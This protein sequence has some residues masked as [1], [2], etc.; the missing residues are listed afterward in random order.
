MILWG[1][2]Q[3]K[4]RRWE[5]AREGLPER[6][7]DGIAPL[8]VNIGILWPNRYK[9]TISTTILGYETM[10]VRKSRKPV[11]KRLV[12]GVPVCKT[13][14]QAGTSKSMARQTLLKWEG[15]DLLRASSCFYCF[16]IPSSREL[17][18]LLI[19]P[20]AVVHSTRWSGP[21]NL[22]TDNYDVCPFYLIV[23]QVCPSKCF[24]YTWKRRSWKEECCHLRSPPPSRCWDWKRESLLLCLCPKILLFWWFGAVEVIMTNSLG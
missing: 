11:A 21:L 20:P 13:K 12:R 6:K 18:C 17:L 3:Q 16:S 1:A 19:T 22:Y 2:H 4:K 15:G 9:I 24:L 5:R 10:K 7:K 8:S 23:R 14:S